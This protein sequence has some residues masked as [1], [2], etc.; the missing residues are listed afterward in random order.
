MTVR[1]STL[2]DHGAN[3][4]AESE[5]EQNQRRATEHADG[6]RRSISRHAAEIRGIE[7]LFG[8]PVADVLTRSFEDVTEHA[9]EESWHR[10]QIERAQADRIRWLS[11]KHAELVERW[12]E[13]RGVALEALD[14]IVANY[15]RA[16]RPLPDHVEALLVRAQHPCAREEETPF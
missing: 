15:D 3:Q 7:A 1:R 6:V 2:T 13:A 16:R 9:S 11:E 5:L 4:Q 10:Q 12:D 8:R 14:V